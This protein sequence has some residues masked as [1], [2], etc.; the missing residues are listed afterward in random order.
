MSIKRIFTRDELEEMGL[1]DD[2]DH[3]VYTE[4]IDER[5]WYSIHEL[6]FRVEDD[7]PL[8]RVNY[9]EPLTELQEHDTWNDADHVEAVQVEPYEVAVTRYRPVKDPALAES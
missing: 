7:G 9:Y 4:Q 5:R 6:V 1:P 8:W 3:T 2:K